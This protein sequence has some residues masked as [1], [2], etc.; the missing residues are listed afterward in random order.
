MLNMQTVM[1]F[2]NVNDVLE[3]QNFTESFSCIQG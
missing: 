3:E 2:V 1:L